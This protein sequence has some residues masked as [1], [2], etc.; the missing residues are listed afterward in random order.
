MT[1]VDAG[2]VNGGSQDLSVVVSILIGRCCVWSAPIA[3][4]NVLLDGGGLACDWLR[5]N[6][7]TA[8]A[9]REAPHTRQLSV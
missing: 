8:G 7:S 6:G 3:F 4:A 2:M 9:E 5:T 1:G